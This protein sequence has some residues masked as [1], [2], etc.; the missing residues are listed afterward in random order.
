MVRTLLAHTQHTL[1]TD[2]AHTRHTLKAAFILLYCWFKATCKRLLFFYSINILIFKQLL[3][4][5][6]IRRGREADYNKLKQNGTIL[7]FE[8]CKLKQT[9]ATY[10]KLKQ[11]GAFL[12]FGKCKL[13][14]TEATYNKWKQTQ[15]VLPKGLKAEVTLQGGRFSIRDMRPE[16][17]F[18]GTAGLEEMKN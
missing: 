2:S 13:K 5:M 7:T 8:K 3:V 18:E 12:T 10:N 15:R 6:C 11:N 1:V 9:E 4:T 14:Q 17:I 16:T